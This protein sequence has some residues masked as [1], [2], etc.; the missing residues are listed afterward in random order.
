MS[1]SIHRSSLPPA[2]SRPL[3]LSPLCPLSL[4]FPFSFSAATGEQVRV[5]KGHSLGCSC[6]A[7]APDG[8][9][10]ASGAWDDTVRVFSA[11]TGEFLKVLVGHTQPVVSVAWSPDGKWLASASRDR[12]AR[13]WSNLGG[14]G[15][16]PRVLDGHESALSAAAFSPDGRLLAT[17]SL[18]KTARLWAL[19]GPSSSSGTRVAASSGSLPTPA[20]SATAAPRLLYVLAGHGG[21]VYG[22]S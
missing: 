12:T 16:K 14:P 20:I 8:L 5:I 6:V 17:C 10:L 3:I 7:W 13:L 1:E 15:T 21:A 11:S 9:S 2:H 4:F 18:D 19:W 22:C